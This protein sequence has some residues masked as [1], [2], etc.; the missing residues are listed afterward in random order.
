MKRLQGDLSKGEN[1]ASHE[2]PVGR[3][4]KKTSGKPTD[5]VDLWSANEVGPKPACGR[6]LPRSR[7]AVTARHAN[8]TCN[9]QP[10]LL[11]NSTKT[12]PQRRNAD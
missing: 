2:L 5:I 3:Q 10:V 6:L 12:R 7:P 1:K 8:F 9:A 11:K 4:E